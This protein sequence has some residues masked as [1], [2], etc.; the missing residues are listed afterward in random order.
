MTTIDVNTYVTLGTINQISAWQSLANAVEQ[1]KQSATGKPVVL[2]FYYT[3]LSTTNPILNQL[4]TDPDVKF[5]CYEGTA[6]AKILQT[7]ISVLLRTNFDKISPDKFECKRLEK[8]KVLSVK[9]QKELSQ[10]N[11]YKRDIRA[12]L[13]KVNTSYSEVF[14]RFKDMAV[15]KDLQNL[16]HV[17]TGLTAFFE[18]LRE[19]CKERNITSLLVSLKDVE[20]NDVLMASHIQTTMRKFSEENMRI[21]FT[22]CK[23]G[24]E[25]KLR[26][27]IKQRYTN[28]SPRDVLAFI[29]KLGV[30][31]VVLL[32]KLK[33]HNSEEL[34]YREEDEVVAQYIGIIEGYSDTTVSFK[35]TGFQ[36]L[37][38]FHDL[39]AKYGTPEEFDN[40]IMHNIEI[41][42]E[43]LGCTNIRV[44]KSWHLDLF[45]G[46]GEGDP[47]LLRVATRTSET[48]QSLRKEEVVLLPEF[49]RRSLRSWHISFN[50]R[51]L[52][53]DI[54]TFKHNTR[55]K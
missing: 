23:K 5:V 7:T 53:S 41:D 30:G 33:D 24:L 54:Q 15:A 39:M 6:T 49:I 28:G 2:T 55:R 22:D 14:V 16:V 3:A 4:I 50:E 29:E 25:N 1:A 32:T 36:N 20:Y 47:N 43:V 42:L 8:T 13:D 21:L 10:M 17:A 38:T 19:V 18:A 51:A 52:L 11:T 37:A 40:L 48:I 26:L 44:A 12:A 31:R 35:Y 45:D 9:Q 34:G 46:N 27:H